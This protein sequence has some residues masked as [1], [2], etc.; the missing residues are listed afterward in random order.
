V[1]IFMDEYGDGGESTLNV[2]YE[3]VI[4]GG[5][6]SPASD[7]SEAAWFPL[8]HLPESIA[9]ENSREALRVLR[10]VR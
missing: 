2:Y 1:G 10:D 5:E 4:R 6:I 3:T 9:F 7:V 8:D